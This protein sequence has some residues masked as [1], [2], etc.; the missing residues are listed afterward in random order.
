MARRAAGRGPQPTLGV[1]VPLPWPRSLRHA[2]G[3][4]WVAGTP[5]PLGGD[6]GVKGVAEQTLA[7]LCL[8]WLPAGLPAD[9]HQRSPPAARREKRE[10]KPPTKR[11]FLLIFPNTALQ[12]GGL[13]PCS[14]TPSHPP[15]SSSWRGG[16]RG[17]GAARGTARGP[18]VQGSGAV[19]WPARRLHPPFQKAP[20]TVKGPH[21][22]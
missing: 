16:R 3:W 10:T 8:A 13:V 1:A 5:T 15:L 14:I 19:P 6:R 22:I 9:R 20:G 21:Q 4:G 17:G 18:R 2:P 11:S 7:A 12:P